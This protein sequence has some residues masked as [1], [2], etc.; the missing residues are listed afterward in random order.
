MIPFNKVEFTG[1]EE[2]YVKQA[3]SSGAIASDKGFTRR[4][5]GLIESMNEAKKAL[6]TTS[7]TDALEMAAI[8]C[9]VQP[10]DEVIVP[11]FTFVSTANAFA[12]R[13]AKLVFCDIRADTL[14]MDEE[15]LEGL[16][17]PRTKAI[18]PVHYAGVGCEMDEICAIAARHGVKVIED[19]AHGFLGR[20]KGRL[21]G[22]FG[23]MSTLSFHE[24]KNLTC[25]EG[26][27]LLLNDES[28][29]QR[30]EIIRD[31][32][33]NRARFFR[34]EIDK[35]SWVDIGSSYCMSDVLAA[36]LTAQL[37]DVDNIQ[38][39]RKTVWGR[40]NR[41]LADWC[42]FYGIDGPC[43]PSYC[44]QTYH[45]HYLLMPHLDSRQR[46]IAHLK[47]HGIQAT[48]HY[49]PLNRSEYGSRFGGDCPV[50]EDIADRLVRLPLYSSLS[51][52]D[53]SHIINTIKDF[54]P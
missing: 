48:F 7:C 47:D 20:Y 46:F 42:E 53:Q 29:I 2:A 12:L 10:G 49:G 52:D 22:T 23:S 27:A 50:T 9:D 40:Y 5:Q 30:A 8:L 54:V 33:T 17:T 16:I 25:G 1:S 11:A 45:M 37:E 21:L 18:V 13:G 14:N 43:I 24:T 38:T 51:Y 28:L 41:E 35:Y 15:L 4:A 31:K 44:D 34:G 39:R 32:G 26:G 19:N 6:L 3:L 36:L